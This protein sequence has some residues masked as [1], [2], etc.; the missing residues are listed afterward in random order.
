MIWES[1]YWQ[2]DLLKQAAELN[3]RRLQ[4]RDYDVILYNPIH[5]SSEHPVPLGAKAANQGPQADGCRRALRPRDVAATRCRSKYEVVSLDVG[6][7][8]TRTTG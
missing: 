5:T 2:D 7:E 3:K 8:T 6:G 1:A 4:R